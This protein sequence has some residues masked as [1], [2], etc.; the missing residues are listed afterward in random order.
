MA[1]APR[2]LTLTAVTFPRQL[3]H[4]LPTVFVTGCPVGWSGWVNE[5]TGVLVVRF[6][7][8]PSKRMHISRVEH[9]QVSG[10]AATDD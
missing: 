10:A 9:Y 7:E 5:E 1:A 8:G 4:D 6:K 3:R 2:K